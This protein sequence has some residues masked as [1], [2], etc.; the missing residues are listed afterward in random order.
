MGGIMNFVRSAAAFCIA[1]FIAANG[2]GKQP[3]FF[4]ATAFGTNVENNQEWIDLY[5]R[6]LEGFKEPSLFEG[7]RPSISQSYRLLWLRSFHKPVS[8]RLDVGNDGVGELTIKLGSR[9]GVS[10]VDGPVDQNV[11]RLTKQETDRFLRQIDALGFWDL[12]P[13]EEPVGG[14]DGAR[15]LLEGVRDSRYHAVHRWTPKGGAVRTLG[16]ELAIDLG[17][18]KIPAGQIY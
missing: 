1:L 10:F 2:S 14:P 5:S 15:W 9:P 13:Q 11:R 8:V 18:L 17:K 16:L 12:A 3:R 4:P 6:Y 7:T